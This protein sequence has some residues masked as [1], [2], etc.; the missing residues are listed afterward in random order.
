MRIKLALRHEVMGFAFPDDT[1]VDVA[2]ALRSIKQER[3]DVY[4]RL[5][6][7]EGQSLEAL[8]IL[9]NGEHIRYRRGLN[10]ELNDGDEL[11]IVPHIAGG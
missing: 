11:R 1:S 5:V 6:Q 3:P 10:T 8:T 9:V 7:A 4:R 2:S